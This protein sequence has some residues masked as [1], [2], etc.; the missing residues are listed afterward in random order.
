[1]LE[2]PGLTSSGDLGKDLDGLRRYIARLVPALEME[3]ITAKEDDYQAEYNAQKLGVGVS[4]KRS[5]AGALAAHELRQDNPHRVTAAQLGLTLDRLVT[6]EFAGQGLTARIGEKRGLQVNV[7]SAEASVSSWTQIGGT[8][9]ADVNLGDWAAKI[10]VLYAVI[11]MMRAGSSKEFWPG[12]ISGS[13]TDHIGTLRIHRGCAIDTNEGAINSG[14]ISEQ[15][16]IPL[17]V[18]GLGV[19]GYGG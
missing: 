13:D 10:P 5:T 17:T 6:I 12:I 16:T 3:L 1:M 2:L 11:P 8:A 7:Q 9:W 19:F 14:T 15:V 18:I 4:D